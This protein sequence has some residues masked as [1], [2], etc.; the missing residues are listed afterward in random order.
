MSQCDRCGITFN[1]GMV[2]SA[3]EAPCWCTQLPLLPAP[4]LGQDSARCYCADCLRQLL[5]HSAEVQSPT[6]NH[7]D[8]C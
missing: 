3:A 6:F 7:K 1:C 5:A 4:V 2:D 8:D